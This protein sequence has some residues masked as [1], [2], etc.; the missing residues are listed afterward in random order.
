MFL[1]FIHDLSRASDE[2]NQKSQFSEIS[3]F[4]MIHFI[5]SITR[6]GKYFNRCRHLLNLVLATKYRMNNVSLS[7]KNTRDQF[8]KN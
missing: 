5:L 7:S 4:H 3:M 8:D 6:R 2:V 1:L